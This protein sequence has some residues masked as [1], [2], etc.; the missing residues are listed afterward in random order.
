VRLNPLSFPRKQ[1]WIDFVPRGV[2][3]VIAPW[4]YPLANNFRSLFPALLCGNGV[5]LKPSEYASA[6][7]RWVVELLSQFLPHDL[8]HLAEGDGAVGRALLE[9]GIDA[10]VFT[11]S[12]ATGRKV[13][14]RCAELGIPASVELGGNDPAIVLADA[15][16]DRA[17]QGITHWALH[18]AGQACGAVELALVD[19]PIA[20]AL[21]DRLR[22]AWSHLR[23][24]PGR[25]GETEVAPLANRRQF[26]IVQAHVEEARAAGAEVV[27][28]G[29]ATG[30]GLGFAPT[31]LDRCTPEMRVVQEETFGPVLAVVRV[32]GAD[33]AIRLANHLAYGLTASIWSQDLERAERL[34]ERLDYGTV[35]INNHS[36]TGAIP[37][38]PWSGTRNSGTGIANSELSLTTFLRPKA[39]AVDH[40]T[41]P[42]LYWMP[43]DSD[44]WQLGDIL[45]DAMLGHIERAWRLP[46]IMRRRK[47]TIRSFFRRR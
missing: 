36:F 40:A 44:L 28:G 22:S 20:D 26:E 47:R 41:S 21:V 9:S 43:F 23:V 46:G 19:A 18:N 12:V 38:L 29:H 45:A 25:F 8:I 2:V 32:D 15:N 10:C 11:G 42:E 5:I 39:V 4:N 27:V 17:A 35:T 30:E 6:T 13:A 24:A 37:A 16:L 1:A 33:Q 3:G 14:T 34:A 7:G 31:V